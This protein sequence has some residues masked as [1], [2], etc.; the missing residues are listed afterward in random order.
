MHAASRRQITRMLD[1]FGETPEVT[2]LDLGCL[3]HETDR[4]SFPEDVDGAAG[5]QGPRLA[6]RPQR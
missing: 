2:A 4:M 1:I 3:N 6:C 5:A